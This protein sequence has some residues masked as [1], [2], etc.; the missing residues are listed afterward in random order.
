MMKITGIKNGNDVEMEIKDTFVLEKETL[1]ELEGWS[2]IIIPEGIMMIDTIQFKGFINLRKIRIPKTVRFLGDGSFRGCP[3]L[4]KIAF[5]PS[6]ECT[7]IG[8]NAFEGCYSL[9][10]VNIPE[11]VTQIGGY[12]FKRCNSLKSLSLPDLK[13]VP[14][15]LFYESGITEINIPNTV[16]KIKFEAFSSCYNLETVIINSSECTVEDC[17][18][19]DCVS[20]KKVDTPKSGKFRYPENAFRDCIKLSRVS[21]PKGI[22]S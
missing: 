2:E 4:E 9:E 7:E 13:I 22:Y 11:M 19:D 8:A 18:F 1:K 10:S 3:F 12:A 21:I 17:V 14:R 6:S 20:L 16:S 15:G 5:A